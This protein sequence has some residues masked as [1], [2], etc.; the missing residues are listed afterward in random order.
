MYLLEL[1]VETCYTKKLI[2]SPI[3]I[4][5]KMT[6]TC[7]PGFLHYFFIFKQLYKTILFT[8]S[9]YIREE[10]NRDIVS[11]EIIHYGNQTHFPKRSI[12]FRSILYKG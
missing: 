2:K 6:L 11:R 4:L 9:Q 3:Q 1:N 10:K 5:F 7:K 12:L 8:V